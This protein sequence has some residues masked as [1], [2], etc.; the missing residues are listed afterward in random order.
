M[1]RQSR[2]LS[3]RLGGHRRGRDSSSTIRG[4]SFAQRGGGRRGGGRGW[5]LWGSSQQQLLHLGVELPK[6]GLHDVKPILHLL[7]VYPESRKRAHR[8]PTRLQALLQLFNSIHPLSLSSIA[9]S[10][11]LLCSTSNIFKL[12]LYL[13][14]LAAKLSL[15]FLKL[16]LSFLKLSTLCRKLNHL[17]FHSSHSLA[18]GGGVQ[19]P[20]SWPQGGN[21]GL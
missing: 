17:L 3:R 10:R 14:H 7:Q 4:G 1:S 6:V 9:G 13:H 8:F 19:L 11:F 15:S 2:W 18:H 16:S 20:R 21:F 5:V 12:L